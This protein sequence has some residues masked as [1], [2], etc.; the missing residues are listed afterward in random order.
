MSFEKLNNYF[1]IYS[2]HE[3]ISF[4][5]NM[6][7]QLDENIII[8]SSLTAALRDARQ[9]TGRNL[10]TGED[11]DSNKNEKSGNWL[12][13][14]GYLI[15]LDQIGKCYKPKKSIQYKDL[16]PIQ[17]S[18]KYFTHHSDL[19]INA[20][21]ALR[22]GF[23]HDYSTSNSNAKYVSYQHQFTLLGFRSRKIV[24]L[25]QKQWNGFSDNK[26]K[27]NMTIISLP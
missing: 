13:A 1:N 4:H 23:A 7:H 21:Y 3:I 2:E 12:G 22:N 24:R 11:L 8:F 6:L 18:L 19:E 17:R 20:I 10:E 9:N 5:L 26:T 16:S 25:P 14:I 27:E 15:I